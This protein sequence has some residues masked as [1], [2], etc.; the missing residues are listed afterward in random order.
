MDNEAR[1]AWLGMIRA[2]ESLAWRE[3]CEL[4]GEANLNSF[5]ERHPLGRLDWTDDGGRL[6]TVRP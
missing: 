1:A 4:Y 3:Q 2:A 5:I 6:H